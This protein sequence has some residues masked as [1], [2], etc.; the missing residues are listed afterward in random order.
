MKLT[1]LCAL[2]AA[3]ALFAA[4]YRHID[5]DDKVDFA[6]FKTFSVREGRINTTAPEV[7]NAFI[8]G[9]IADAIRT[10]LAAKGLTE[11]KAQADLIAS[12]EIGTITGRGLDPST[13]R[14]SRPQAFQYVD[15]TVVVDLEAGSGNL[16]WRGVYRD[17]ERN[18][19]KFAQK[20]ADRV[21]KL[22]GEYPPRHRR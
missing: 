4:D 12:F 6:T 3:A 1:A 19:A 16:V 17:D 21:K 2:L 5:F 14:G 8:R 13:E 7:S 20:L 18:P 10:A 11:T 15:S 9:S 22:L